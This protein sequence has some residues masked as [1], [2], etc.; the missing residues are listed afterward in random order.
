MQADI[1]ERC[2]QNVGREEYQSKRARHNG[3]SERQPGQRRHD[4]SSVICFSCR[5]GNVHCAGQNKRLKIRSASRPAG[6][7]GTK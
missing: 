4:N 5:R 1:D 6:Q 2:A 7:V 3:D